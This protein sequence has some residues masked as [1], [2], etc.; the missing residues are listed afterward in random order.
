MILLD[1]HVFVWAQTH[2]RK[3]SRA[4]HSAIRRAQRSGGIAISVISVVEMAGL[5]R[6]GRLGL[7]GSFESTINELIRDVVIKPITTEI[8]VMTAEFPYEFPSDPADRIIAATARAEN[9]PLV[10]A[11]DRLLRC[12]VLKTIW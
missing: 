10:T 2:S 1:T 4:A 3:L 7:R 11:D 6:C 9:L 5:L 12:P 8:A